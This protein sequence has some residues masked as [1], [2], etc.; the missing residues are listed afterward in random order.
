MI[1]CDKNWKLKKIDLK[2][3]ENEE[4]DICVVLCPE[5]RACIHGVVKFPNGKPVEN[6]C[7]KLFK[8]K[9]P[10]CCDLIPITFCFTDK[11]GQFLFGV[12]ACVDLVVKVFFFC[13]ETKDH[14]GKDD[15]DC[16]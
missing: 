3:A 5:K 15:C 2:L 1:T 11:C 10:D 13:P 16:L 4:K 14:D 6:A 8:K 7:V 9:G 12:P